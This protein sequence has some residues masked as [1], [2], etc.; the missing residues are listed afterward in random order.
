MIYKNRPSAE[1]Q[2]KSAGKQGKSRSPVY[3]SSA[4]YR[5]QTPI[6]AMFELAAFEKPVTVSFKQKVSEYYLLPASTRLVKPGEYFLW[7]PS[8]SQ[9][10]GEY[11]IGFPKGLYLSDTA[12]VTKPAPPLF[13][14]LLKL[15][16]ELWE[17]LRRDLIDSE[18]CRMVYTNSLYWN[19]TKRK[20]LA[21]PFPGQYTE[22][23]LEALRPFAG[24]IKLMG[25]GTLE[26]LKN[27]SQW[28]KLITEGSFKDEFIL[29]YSKTKGDKSHFNSEFRI[30]I[31]VLPEHMPAMLS[32]LCEQVI[33]NPAFRTI[34]NMKMASEKEMMRRADNTLIYL[35]GNREL[36]AVLSVILEQQKKCPHYFGNELPVMV[37]P[38][39]P[40][41]G[42]AETPSRGLLSNRETVP[43]SY[44]RE[45]AAA[46]RAALE[47][48]TAE[49]SDFAD[50]AANTAE[51]MKS[52]EEQSADFG[53]QVKALPNTTLRY[54]QDFHMLY[55]QEEFSQ[56]KE[57]LS[58]AK[59]RPV[60]SG[61]T[62]R[63]S[64]SFME[65]RSV[66]ISEAMIDTLHLGFNAFVC[67]VWR[68]FKEAKLDFF[69]PSKNMNP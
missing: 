59:N 52:L 48:K 60:N 29:I 42:I 50:K 44:S 32:F 26:M 62:P 23:F 30:Y 1:A 7:D 56:W 11:L 8:Y 36:D 55:F 20:T 65:M 16:S 34:S 41:I 10:P 17:K 35:Y 45:K 37:E 67:E 9:K 57:M 51:L 66:V 46:A 24:E 63:G 33:L 4:C 64:C 18:N 28:K 25:Q 49:D 39:G 38:K 61:I 43:F 6:Q 58:S 19:L 2:R 3:K 40:G 68:R 27:P 15:L 47:K 5:E 12:P 13:Q 31:N 53:E 21:L 22:G 14:E 69:N 54:I